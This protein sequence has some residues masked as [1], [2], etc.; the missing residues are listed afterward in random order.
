M[1]YIVNQ[2]A[3]IKMWHATDSVYI[4]LLFV[5]CVIILLIPVLVY[6]LLAVFYKKL[7]SLRIA[8]NP[9]LQDDH[10]RKGSEASK[11]D[12]YIK[13]MHISKGCKKRTKAA[14]KRK[15]AR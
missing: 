10:E 6:I 15:R 1:A 13:G 2:I 14:K 7:L 3:G 12:T 9:W 11:A 4:I 8:S 5:P